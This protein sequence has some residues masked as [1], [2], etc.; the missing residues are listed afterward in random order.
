MKKRWLGWSITEVRTL[1]EGKRTCPGQLIL[2]CGRFAGIPSFQESWPNILVVPGKLTSML[3]DL[4]FSALGQAG[5]ETGWLFWKAKS[6]AETQKT[7][8]F[9]HKSD[10]AL[11]IRDHESQ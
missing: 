5:Q 9:I 6:T 10:T 11:S 1:D 8:R 7:V 3:E 4:Y 2:A